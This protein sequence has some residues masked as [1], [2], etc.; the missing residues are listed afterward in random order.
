[1]KF[2]LFYYLITILLCSIILYI[3]HKKIKTDY[4]KELVLK[5][6]TITTVILHYSDVWVS[7]FTTGTPD[8]GNS[9]MFAI[10]PCHIMM[11]LSLIFAF[12]SKKDTRIGHVL[13]DFMFYVGF[14]C[15]TIGIV[16]NDSYL[17]TPDLGDYEVLKGLLSHSTLLLGCLY[18]FV[19]KYVK[20]NAFRNLTSAIVGFLVFI[21]DGVFVI[22]LFKLF[23][24]DPVN[25][26]YLLE[27]P[28]A[29]LPFINTATIG[30]AGVLAVFGLATAME[31]FF[32]PKEERWINKI[33]HKGEEKC[34][35]F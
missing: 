12:L 27:P 18:V 11:W 35:N 16:V 6:I 10:Y 9:H 15:G 1:M 22:N 20:V 19:M 30:I 29:D 14:F 5:I 25:A 2:L 33:S 7:Y 21:V 4:T 13:A 17:S 28:F 26:M 32:L 23:D 31:Y 8:V 3:C 34:T 24:I